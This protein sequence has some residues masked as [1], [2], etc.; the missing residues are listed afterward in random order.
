M[1]KA[2][3][4]VPEPNF[5][6]EIQKRTKRFTM[7]E[8]HFHD[9]FEIYFLLSGRRYYFIENMTYAV[10]P[11]DIVFIPPNVIHKT[12]EAGSNEHERVLIV[13]QKDYFGDIE[14]DGILTE[15]FNTNNFVCKFKPHRQSYIE[16]LVKKIYKEWENKRRFFNLN[17]K[18]MDTELLVYSI[19]NS[20]DTNESV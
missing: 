17:I 7:D 14:E 3:E 4:L 5:K 10:N 9:Y 13:F 6:I 2:S 20:E 15:I 19:R 12:I 8:R 16:N 1:K 18:A 11:G